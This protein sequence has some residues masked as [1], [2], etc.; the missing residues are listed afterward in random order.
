MHEDPLPGDVE[1]DGPS[2]EDQAHG[3]VVSLAVDLAVAK[4]TKYAT[5]ESGDTVEVIERPTGGVSV[6]TVDGQGSGR[7][8][9]TLS[10]L[11]TAKAVALLKEGARDGAVARAVHD[12]LFAFRGGQVSATLD[13]LS[14]DFS[15]QAVVLTR[16]AVTPAVA[17][18]RDSLEMVPV[19]SGPIGRYPRTRPEVVEWPMFDGLHVVTVTDGIAAAGERSGDG[20]FDVLAFLRTSTPGVYSAAELADR[21]LQ[22]AIRRD[23]GKPG[24]DLT[25]VALV[26]REHE[27][28]PLIRRLSLSV[29]LPS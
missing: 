12:H 6:I 25:V 18:C 27:E 8:A 22:E 13:I 29:P 15:A 5:R 2:D 1:V 11:L 7:A 14:V 17:G 24:D 19:T 16:N 21:V 28:H 10:L 9:K 23:A 20:S 4:T 26:L 3:G